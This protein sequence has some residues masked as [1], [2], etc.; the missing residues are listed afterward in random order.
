MFL[1]YNDSTQAS[2]FLF[3]IFSYGIT[4]LSFLDN[5]IT[6]TIAADLIFHD[7][8][9]PVRILKEAKVRIFPSN[10]KFWSPTKPRIQEEYILQLKEVQYVFF[11]SVQVVDCYNLLVLRGDTWIAFL[12]T[13]SKKKL[14]LK[15]LGSSGSPLFGLP[16]I[17]YPLITILQA[18]FLRQKNYLD[19]CFYY[20][21]DTRYFLF[22]ILF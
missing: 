15:F 20:F 17:F 21:P 11:L 22:S 18:R 13:Y 9:E 4:S 6:M 8:K 2:T 14:F 12:L 1:F 10:E 7:L 16:R 5:R 19:Y 3:T